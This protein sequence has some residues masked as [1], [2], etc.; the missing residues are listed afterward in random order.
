MAASKANKSYP[1]GKS[2]S[3]PPTKRARQSSGGADGSRPPEDPSQ[4]VVEGYPFVYPWSEKWRPIFDEQIE[5]IREDIARAKA[6]DKLIVYLS[7]PISSRGGGDSR[8]NVEIARATEVRLLHEW[9]HRFWFLNPARYQ[10]ESKEGVGLM[11]RHAK[12][13]GVPLPKSPPSGGDYMRMWTKVL[14]EETPP[15]LANPNPEPPRRLGEQFDAYYFLGPSDVHRFFGAG[16][17]TTLTDA[18]EAG[19]ARSY[20]TD[21]DFR[22]A[23]E[24]PGIEW[25][26]KAKTAPNDVAAP[27]KGL[28]AEW[29]ERRKKYFRYYA[30]R[31]GVNYS[32]GSHDEWNILVE[33]NKRR[34]KAL[35]KNGL[36]GV[37][38]LLAGFFEGRQVAPGAAVT[39]VDR[40]YDTSGDAPTGAVQESWGSA[41]VTSP[42]E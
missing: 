17:G 34:V 20:A 38:D 4:P 42:A 29:E 13:L 26:Q 2:K 9:G 33:I 18:I 10:M 39:Q 6:S 14:I 21:P 16:H 23:Y 31:A 15:K 27:P 30:V 3:N 5:L 1:S 7:C 19:L 40:G 28:R 12:A 24:V 25:G 36:P 22:D 41:R 32:L 8:T 35:D 11:E 37:G